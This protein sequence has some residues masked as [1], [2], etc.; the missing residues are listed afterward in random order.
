[1]ASNNHYTLMTLCLIW[2][3]REM[4][5]L[6]PLRLQQNSGRKLQLQKNWGVASSTLEVWFVSKWTYC[7]WA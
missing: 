6:W 2:S 1:L 7:F 4:L 3:F 5:W